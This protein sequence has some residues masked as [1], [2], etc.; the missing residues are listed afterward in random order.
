MVPRIPCGWL[1]CTQGHPPRYDPGLLRTILSR[2]GQHS[3]Q[4]PCVQELYA[5]KLEILA[6]SAVLTQFPTLRRL[7]NG[8]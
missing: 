7:Q 1:Y 5:T 3:M 4:W 8:R 6:G 2:T